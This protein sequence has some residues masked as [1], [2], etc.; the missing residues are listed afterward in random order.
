MPQRARLMQRANSLRLADLAHTAHLIAEDRGFH[1]GAFPITGLAFNYVAWVNQQLT[2]L[3]IE[4][5]E[6][7]D[8]FRKEGKLSLEEAADVFIVL[9]DLVCRTPELGVAFEEA[10]QEKLRK[11]LQRE[12]LYGKH[13]D[14]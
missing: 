12:K 11:N 1:G 3:V 9:G 8:G 7:A 14:E 4:V 6:L 13:K 5:G 10:I 2:H